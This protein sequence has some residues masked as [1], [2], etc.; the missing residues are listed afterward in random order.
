MDPVKNPFAPG[1]GS[2]P[3]ELAGRDALLERARIALLR[4]KEG[5]HAKSL[6]MLGLRGV[7]KTVLLNRIKQVA[8]AEG[9]L[10]SFIEATESK[11]L[12]RLLLPELRRLLFSL[13]TGERVSAAARRALAIFR[14]FVGSLKIKVDDVEFGVDID[15]AKGEADSGDLEFDLAQV[16]IALGAAASERKKPILIL[17]DEVQYLSTDDLSALIMAIH[18]LSQQQLPVLV[19]GAGLPQL[20]GL[21]GNSKSYAERLFDYPM[22]GPL[23]ANDIVDAVRDPIEREG[24]R[25]DQPALQEIQAVSRGYPYF[26]QAWGYQAWNEAS[27][28][29]I[30]LQDV[31]SATPKAIR[32]LDESFFRVRF[33][34]LTP[35]EKRYLR[36]MAELGEGPHRSGDI[37]QLLNKDV[38]QVA[39]LRNGLIRKG[40]IFSPAHGDTAFTVP[41][42]DTYLKRVIPKL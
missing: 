10:T 25:I 7:G 1:A 6:M 17:I 5:R 30:S 26:L 34:R 39:P 11:P 32:Q 40:M 2:P 9:Y 4:T 16:F 13:N 41:L 14:S 31:Q 28:D 22:V 3:P 37:A 15:P 19:I 36:A 24:A 35:S 18:Q 8:E 38:Q 21:A 29:K 27:D 42:F 20:A 12:P 23:E 33:D